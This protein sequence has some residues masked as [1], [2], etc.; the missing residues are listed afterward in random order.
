MRISDWS[1]DVCSSDLRVVDSVQAVALHAEVVMQVL[2][3]AIADGHDRVGIL[4]VSAHGLRGAPVLD[5]LA[6]CRISRQIF[7]LREHAVDLI[8]KAPF[9]SCRTQ[10]VVVQ[11]GG[12]ANPGMFPDTAP[13]PETGTE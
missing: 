7:A 3:K 12:Q 5:G 9:Q 10:I 8:A 11:C 6:P 1:S 13:P 2:G 4:E